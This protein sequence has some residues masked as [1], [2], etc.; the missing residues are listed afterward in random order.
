MQITKSFT[1]N[2]TGKLTSLVYLTYKIFSLLKSPN[3]GEIEPIKPL[4]KDKSLQ[5]H[6]LT[7]V[8]MQIHTIE[9][10]LFLLIY[11]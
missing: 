2:D 1:W 8:N 7:Q 9:D 3:C 6:E 4:L 10:F 5:L 11:D